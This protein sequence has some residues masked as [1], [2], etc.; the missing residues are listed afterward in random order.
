MQL[1]RRP[2][3]VLFSLGFPVLLIIAYSAEL[4]FIVTLY[5]ALVA[6]CICSD[7]MKNPL[8]VPVKVLKRHEV[9]NDRSKILSVLAIVI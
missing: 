5:S 6:C 8:I 3:A 2:A 9:V 7:L 1:S 4:T